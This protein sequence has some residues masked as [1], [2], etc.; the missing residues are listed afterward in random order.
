MSNYDTGQMIT[1]KLELQ[2]NYYES[3]GLHQEMIQ[4]FEE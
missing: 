3:C 4:V 1:V 2:I